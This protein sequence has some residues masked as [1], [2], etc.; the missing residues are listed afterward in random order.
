MRLA[1][2]WIRPPTA[3]LLGRSGCQVEVRLCHAQTGMPVSE[4][5][6]WAL[7]ETRADGTWE[8]VLA[9]IPVGGPYRLE[10]RLNP[11]GNKTREWAWRG[12]QRHWLS[13]GD[14]YVIAG[15]SNASGYGAPP[16]DEAPE[17]GLHLF[18]QDGNWKLAC[19]PLHDGTGSRHLAALQPYVPG[20]SPY[21]RFA[22]RLR[23]ATGRPIALIPTA[24]GGSFLREWQ[25]DGALYANMLAMVGSAGVT[26]KAILFA[27]G[28]S[29]AKGEGSLDYDQR[30]AS[31]IATW[32]KEFK[33]FGCPSDLPILAT[34][35]GRYYSK[36]PGEDDAA[37]SAVREAQRQV[38]AS[39]PKVALMPTLDAPLCDSIHLSTSGNLLVADRLAN[40][41][42]SLVYG[43]AS[44]KVGEYRAP[45]IR[46]ARLI[47]MRRIE[48]SF[49]AVTDRLDH[50]EP[51]ARPFRV[52]DEVGEVGVLRT[53][54]PM[55]D[56]IELQLD[57]APVGRV[58]V[59][60]GW[61]ENPPALPCDVERRMP[62]LAFE[63]YTVT[64]E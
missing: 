22:K 1:G 5:L 17:I 41:A 43:E 51:S 56:R 58:S 49:D 16:Y 33:A 63:N 9:S 45:H 47:D 44:P 12:D 57:R 50:F 61:G 15:Q 32:R 8:H 13:V 64:Q 30:F 4:G 21:L 2:T 36:N 60:A 59:S 40:A 54:Y 3:G 24:L 62:I 35:M 6:Q 39:L 31:A 23:A 34:Q 18:G 46:H 11:K 29:D 28:E 52:L 48:L 37:W 25:A 26:P 7:A 53:V 20:H 42:L 38:L 55:D 27:Q 10:T 14:A 19:H